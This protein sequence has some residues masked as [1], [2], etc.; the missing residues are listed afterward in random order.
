MSFRETRKM[1]LLAYDGNIISDDEFSV[2]W[3]SYRSK[4]PDFPHSSYA[5]FDLQNIVEAECLAEFRVQKQDIPVL[6]NV[7]QLSVNIH[8]PQRTICNRVEGLGM[9][10][11]RF[12]Y[13]CR[14]L[15]HDKP[16]WK[17]SSRVMYDHERS[18]G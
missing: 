17:T 11:K 3:E 4:N 13:P 12:S 16:I 7:L 10:L 6:A 8:C 5:R 1:L 2:L 15:R 14:L 9:L 18:Q